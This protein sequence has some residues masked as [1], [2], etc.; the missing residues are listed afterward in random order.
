MVKD[1]RTNHETS[2]VHGVM[3]GD[4]DG[5]I[6]AYLRSDATRKPVTKKAGEK[7]R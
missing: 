5:F 4:L 7:A 2:D 1:H 6:D 3:D